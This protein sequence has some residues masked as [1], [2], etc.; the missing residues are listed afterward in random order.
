M[1]LFLRALTKRHLVLLTSLL[2][3][4]ILAHIMFERGFSSLD[5]IRRH[6][7]IERADRDKHSTRNEVLILCVRYVMQ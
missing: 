2:D 6:E 5:R 7:T 4:G 1:Q 3:D